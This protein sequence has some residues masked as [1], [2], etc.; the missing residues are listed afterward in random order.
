[1]EY[2][3]EVKN[4]S[5]RFR[6][7]AVQALDDVSFS[8]SP[9]SIMCVTGPNGAGKTT[10][11]KTIAGLI[12]PETGSIFINGMNA[13]KDDS[14]VRSVI[15]FAA[16]QEKGFY[17][18]LTGRQNLNFFGG[19]YGMSGKAIKKRLALLFEEFGID[20]GDRRFD[21]YSAGMKQKFSL[22][23]AFLHDPDILLLDEPTKSLDLISASRTIEYIKQLA[24]TGGKTVIYATHN[25]DEVSTPAQTLLSLESGKVGTAK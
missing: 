22:V 10:L 1:M 16:A 2:S 12:I 8:L 9:G 20:Y 4:V 3:I 11:L 18:R 23:R 7:P 6:R 17:W 15:G 5:K 13:L 25:R 21:S 24:V 19:L 14:R